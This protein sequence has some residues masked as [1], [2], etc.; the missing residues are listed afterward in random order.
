[1]KLL[2][3]LQA[4]AGASNDRAVDWEAVTR[5]AK[6]GTDPGS[7]DMT[8]GEQTAYAVDVREAR[9]AIRSVAGIDFSVPETLEIQNRHHWID[10]NVGT[11]R[12]VFSP[13]E[14]QPVR[15]PTITATINTAS[16]GGSL[17]FIARHVLG[18]YD[19]LLLAD[20]EDDH[21]LY[22][23]HPNIELAAT[24]LD[25]AFP[26]FR[27]W[28]SFHEV[29]HA[30]EF[31]AAPWLRDFLSARL[32]DTVDHLA[33][34]RLPT[35]SLQ[36][37]NRAMTAVEGYAELVMDRAFD[38]EYE[39]LREKLDAR[40]RSGHPLRRFVARLLG[41][42]LKRRQYD[43]GRAFFE[44]VIEDRGIQGAGI[45]WEDP[46]YLPTNRELEEPGR[47]LARVPER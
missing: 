14:D 9:E 32:R 31:G 37:L 26:R 2:D 35:E 1:M 39:D 34:R 18:Q 19:P 10:A 40:R 13:I 28:I 45:V 44:S 11:F 43:V 47:W 17:A 8:E 36:E 15:F 21:G 16:V 27:R 23:V 22:F 46:R 24:E 25:V 6:A 12:R 29:T 42:Q 7:L 5:V 33:D 41:F 38:D 30:A 20:G 3:S 4:V